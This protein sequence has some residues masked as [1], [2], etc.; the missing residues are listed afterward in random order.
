LRTQSLMFKDASLGLVGQI[1]LFF[2]HTKRI[3]G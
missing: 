2:T 3:T 1:R